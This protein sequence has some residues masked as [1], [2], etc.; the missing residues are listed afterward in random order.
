MS[1]GRSAPEG[2]TYWSQNGYHY[3][4]QDGKYRLTHQ[5][6]MEEHLGR[7]L[8]E[9][10]RVRFIDGDRKNL[11]IENLRVVTKGK[12]TLTKQLAQL[13]A[14]RDEL[15]AQIKD[16]EKKLALANDKERLK[17]L[18]DPKHSVSVELS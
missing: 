8:L 3:T 11:T 4:K 1:R 17:K 18:E 14:R 10:E 6:M 12:T 15:N 9:S 5:L 2:A 16:V 7:A 13:I